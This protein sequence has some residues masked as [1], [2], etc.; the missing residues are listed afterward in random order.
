MV[1]ALTVGSSLLLEGVPG[2]GK[3]AIVSALAEQCGVEIIRMNLSD[4]TELADL[5]GQDLLSG[6]N[7][8]D[9][10]F[11]LGRWLLVDG[12]QARLLATAGRAQLGTSASP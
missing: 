12:C 10:G 6:G 2:A 9:Q 7:A 8:D 3:S 5:V 1:C 4:Q 11:P